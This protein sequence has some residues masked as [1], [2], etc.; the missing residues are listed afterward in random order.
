MRARFPT[1]ARRIASGGRRR[2]GWRLGG[3]WLRRGRR[4]G[5]LRG[6]RRGGGRRGGGRGR[7][8]GG[9]GEA[10]VVDRRVDLDLGEGDLLLLGAALDRRL[11]L[12]GVLHAAGVAVVAEIGLEHDRL[13]V[14]QP[15][16]LPVDRQVGDGVDVIVE[17]VAAE[18]R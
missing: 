14:H 1:P 9:G 11:D 4:R 5:R 16:P 2:G 10:G 6:R 15:A 18:Q 17:D 8:D 3:R 13:A 12:E 7:G